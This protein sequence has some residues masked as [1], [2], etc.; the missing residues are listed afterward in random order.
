[1]SLDRGGPSGVRAE[2]WGLDLVADAIVAAVEPGVDLE[3]LAGHK[4]RGRADDCAARLINHL[5]RDRVSLIL[6]GIERLGR[7]GVDFDFER[8][9]GT[10]RGLTG[11]RPTRGG[12]V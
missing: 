7:G 1:M 4:H 5:G 9:V 3:R 10:D 8:T 12:V 6:I 2:K 11:R